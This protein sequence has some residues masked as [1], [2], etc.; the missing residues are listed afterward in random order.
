MGFG[1]VGVHVGALEQVH[2]VLLLFGWVWWSE[3][4]AVRVTFLA[5][6]IS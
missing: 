3:W 6:A 4:V 2:A 1:V 5:D